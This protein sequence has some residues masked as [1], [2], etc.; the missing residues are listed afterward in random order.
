MTSPVKIFIT[1]YL[2]TRD[3]KYDFTILYNMND[4]LSYDLD[5]SFED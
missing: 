1:I 4:F 3:L 5:Q 2:K